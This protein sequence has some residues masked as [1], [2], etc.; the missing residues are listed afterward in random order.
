MGKIFSD[1][2][3]AVL[4]STINSSDTSLTIESGGELFPIADTGANAISPTNGSWFK[5]VLQDTSGIEIVYCRSHAEGSNTFSN[6]L[7]GQEGTTAREFGETSIV[8]NRITSQDAKDWESSVGSIHSVN[9]KSADED[10]KV[11]IEIADIPDLEGDL[12]AAVKI[13]ND[14]VPD[15]EGKVDIGIDDIPGL[16]DALNEAGQVKTVS[17]IEPDTNGNVNLTK[18]AAG[19]NNVDNTA[20]LDKPISIAAASAI[21]DLE[22]A[23]D[24]KQDKLDATPTGNFTA[25]ANKTYWLAGDYEVTLPTPDGVGTNVTFSKAIEATPTILASAGTEIVTEK[26]AS[27]SAVF[28]VNAEITFVFNGTNWEV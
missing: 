5:L 6:L 24:T 1:G 23:L 9:N 7:R 17:G 13:V 16:E 25:T 18:E 8:G 27:E 4:A 12:N 3:R 28:D 21:Q 26:G 11:F 19:L 20:D 15:S 2:A 10:G 22:N 14:I